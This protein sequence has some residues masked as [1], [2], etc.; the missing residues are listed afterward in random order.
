[1]DVESL[2]DEVEVLSLQTCEPVRKG[3]DFWF[4]RWISFK[5]LQEFQDAVFLVVDVESLLGEAEVLL[6]E[7]S[8]PVRKGNNF[9]FDRWIAF[10]IL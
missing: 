3:H 10:K 4:D 7:T 5:F 2:L 8:V 1:V 6:L 9:R